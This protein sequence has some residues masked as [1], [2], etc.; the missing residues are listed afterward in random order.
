M[1]SNG[2]QAKV[3]TLGSKF[4]FFHEWKRLDENDDGN[5]ELATMLRGMCEKCSFIDLLENFIIYDHENDG[6]KKYWRGI[7]N[8]SVSIKL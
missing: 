6:T 7:I 4:E 2:E 3:G 1:L 5:V 8:I